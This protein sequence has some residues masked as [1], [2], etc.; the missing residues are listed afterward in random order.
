MP[1]SQQINHFLTAIFQNVLALEEDFVHSALRDRRVTMTEIHILEQIGPAGARRMGDVAES[2]GVTLPT[3]TASAERLCRKG[4]A[5]KA[6]DG[7]DRRVVNISLTDAGREICRL[8]SEFHRQLVER[9]TQGLAPADLPAFTRL[10]EKVNG[11][12]EELSAQ[13][14]GLPR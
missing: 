3:L 2:L 6:R 9:V 5:S 8:H 13:G 11:F 1:C 12:F 10:L 14:N 4:L 7:A